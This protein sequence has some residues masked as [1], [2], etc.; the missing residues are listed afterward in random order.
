MV[1]TGSTDA[2]AARSR[3]LG[4]AA[5]PQARRQGRSRRPPRP[6][7]RR[8]R[9]GPAADR[10]RRTPAPGRARRHRHLPHRAAPTWRKRLPVLFEHTVTAGMVWVAWPKQAAAKRL[11]LA[12]DLNDNVVRGR[13]AR[14]GLGGRQGRRHR[15]DVVGAEVRTPARRPLTAGRDGRRATA[16]KHDRRG[17]RRAASHGV[18]A[19]PRL[20]RSPPGRGRSGLRKFMGLTVATFAA[21]G[22]AGRPGGSRSRG[23]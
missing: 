10:D 15:R 16:S 1:S 19:A 13:R 21:R 9:P 17:P 8:P 3:L 11:G 23:G 7:A 6:A 5:A 14:P 18:D 12:T 2:T 22:G 4:Y 20:P